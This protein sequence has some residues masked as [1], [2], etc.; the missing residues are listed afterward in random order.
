MC[1]SDRDSDRLETWYF[2]SLGLLPMI[3]SDSSSG[4]K[5]ETKSRVKCRL[6][7]KGIMQTANLLITFP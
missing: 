6:Q 3:S 4:A 5:I 7:A 1:E 2:D